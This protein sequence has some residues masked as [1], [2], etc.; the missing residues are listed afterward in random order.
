MSV[1]KDKMKQIIESFPEDATYEEIIRELVFER[2]ID[3]GL[4]DLRNDRLLSNGEMGQRIRT[5]KK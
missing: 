4:D 3:R 5:W 2:M 1:V